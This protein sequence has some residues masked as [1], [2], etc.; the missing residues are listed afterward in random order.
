M[1]VYPAI[2]LI[3]GKCVRLYKGDF[4]QK[5]TYETTP[6]DMA[7]T[8]RAEGAAWLH[9]VDLDGARD[10]GKRQTGLIR[11][12]IVKSGL[13]VQ[14]G[15]GVR[16]M[17]DVETLLSTGASRVVI[18]SLAVKERDLTK[19]IIAKFGPEKICLAMDVMPQGTDYVVAVSGWQESG[20]VMLDDLIRD[21]LDTGLEHILC[22]DIA[23]DGTMTGCNAA[24]YA[25]TNATFPELQIQASGGVKSLD[26]LRILDTAGVIV[27]KALYE[28]AFTVAEALEAAC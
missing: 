22:T 13:K 10:P 2:D 28:G 9:L 19:S 11:E 25:K 15:G 21:Y 27:G 6:I 1:I 14:T 20:K 17:E 5:T 12:I 26:D 4:A 23:R 3:D 16:S 7:R 8:Y 18:G 24:L